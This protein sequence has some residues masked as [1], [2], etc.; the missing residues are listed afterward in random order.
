MLGSR[1]FSSDEKGDYWFE[2]KS[3]K[4][5]ILEIGIL[6]FVEKEVKI[7]SVVRNIEVVI[8]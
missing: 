3:F 7:F 4:F 6:G 8:L 5:G 1:S 2:M